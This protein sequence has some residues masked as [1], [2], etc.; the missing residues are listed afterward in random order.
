MLW[1]QNVLHGILQRN[2]SFS[3]NSFVK[4]S[5]YNMIHLQHGPFFLLCKMELLYSVYSH[6]IAYQSQLL[7]GAQ[8]LSG[9]VLDLRLRGRRFESH[10]RH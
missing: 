4:L 10:Q 7:S 1:V 6:N 8:W 2:W 9:R 3:N 5:L